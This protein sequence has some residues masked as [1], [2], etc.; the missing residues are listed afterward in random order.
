MVTKIGKFL[1]VLRIKNNESAKE[2]AEKLDISPSYLSAIELGN[3]ALPE[4]IE[5]RII[6]RY[7]MRNKEKVEF[8]DLVNEHQ[9]Y[10]RLDTKELG[11]KKKMILM[12]VLNHDMDESTIEQ[13]CGIIKKKGDDDEK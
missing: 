9:G 12:S 6:N 1:R 13:L 11:E 2:M 4:D 3:R 7:T 5:K 10:I 8:L